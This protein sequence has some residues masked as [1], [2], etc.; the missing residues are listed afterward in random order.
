VDKLSLLVCPVRAVS[1]ASRTIQLGFCGGSFL[2]RRGKH[3]Q[4]R[5]RPRSFDEIVKRKNAEDDKL[6]QRDRLR[7]EYQQSLEG[8]YVPSSTPTSSFRPAVG[9]ERHYNEFTALRSGEAY[10]FPEHVGQ[11]R[12]PVCFRRGHQLQLAR[13]LEEKHRRNVEAE[14]TPGRMQQDAKRTAYVISRN[15]YLEIQS[16]QEQAKEIMQWKEGDETIMLS[17]S[18]E[19]VL[20]DDT[21]AV[22]MDELCTTA[23]AITIAAELLKNDFVVAFP[24]ETVYGLGANALSTPAVQKIFKAK[25]RPSDNP[26]IAHFGSLE[27]LQLFTAVPEAYLPLIDVFWPGPLTI[28]LRVTPEMGVSPLVTAGLD[29]L[30]VRIPSSPL[31]RALILESK[32]PIAAPSANA[33]TRPSPTLASHVYLDLDTRIPLILSADEDPGSECD[34]GLESTVVDGLSS[35]PVILRLGGVSLEAIRAVGGIWKDTIIYEK[36][37]LMAQEEKPRTPGMKYRHYSPRC[38]VYVY[39]YNTPQPSRPSNLLPPSGQE[40]RKIAVLC[41]QNWEPRVDDEGAETQFNWLG[42]NDEDVARNLFRCVREMDEWGAEAIIV[43]GVQERGIGR[44]VMERLRKMA[45][46]NI[47]E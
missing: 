34:V 23:K 16:M 32:L 41:T 12:N 19:D 5:L 36:P 7:E 4:R 45:G 2:Q 30:A 24:T 38:P 26:L 21:D 28:L 20:N 1:S 39:K 10:P 31:A 37:A 3:V 46:G 18:T 8:K 44:S 25:N 22:E 47:L 33:S 11:K 42:S 40:H 17:V 29:T 6:K 9:T 15:R 43:E 27:H 13:Y 35:P 14:K